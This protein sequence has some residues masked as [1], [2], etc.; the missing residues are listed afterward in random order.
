MQQLGIDETRL[1]TQT[2]VRQ[3]HE[4]RHAFCYV[5]A[6]ISC[7]CCSTSIL[8]IFL[9]Q[10][11]YNDYLMELRDRYHVIQHHWHLGELFLLTGYSTQKWKFSH[12]L[13]TLTSQMYMTSFILWNTNG[14]FQKNNPCN[15]SG[16]VLQS[17]R[18]KNLDCNPY[19]P[20]WWI[21]VFWCKMI[22]VWGENTNIY[23]FWPTISSLWMF[24][25]CQHVTCRVSF[26]TSTLW[27]LSTCIIWPHRDYFCKSTFVF[28]RRKS[29]Y[30]PGMAWG[31]CCV[32][33]PFK[34][35]NY[36][37]NSGIVLPFSWHL[38][39]S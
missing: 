38:V 11:M 34:N 15:G 35:W 3:L 24:A 20:S 36:F 10:R 6:C 12:A 27:N 26:T 39:C 31:W 14:N 8:N 37:L 18:F 29:Y 19:D 5:L 17:W 28:L 22:G 32:E 30:T 16:W 23:D 7:E 1:D 13:L 21:T 4:L 2:W 33:H 25:C 9:S